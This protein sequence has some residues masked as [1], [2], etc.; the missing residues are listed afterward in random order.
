MLVEPVR[1]KAVSGNEHRFWKRKP[2]LETKRFSGNEKRF[3]KRKPF[4]EVMYL[5][6]VTPLSANGFSR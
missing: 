1:T 6:F 2:L 4:L 3:W 5:V